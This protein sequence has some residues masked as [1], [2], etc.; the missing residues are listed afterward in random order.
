[1]FL[2]DNIIYIYMSYAW[3]YVDVHICSLS[4]KCLTTILFV[5]YLF[6]VTEWLTIHIHSKN[7]TYI[8]TTQ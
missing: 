2:S 4:Y 3:F 5:L 7:N 1:M 8:N 6:P